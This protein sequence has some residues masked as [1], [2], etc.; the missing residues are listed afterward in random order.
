MSKAH[1]RTQ[2][3]VARCLSPFRETAVEPWGLVFSFVGVLGVGWGVLGR[4]AVGPHTVQSAGWELSALTHV[5]FP[6]PSPP[7]SEESAQPQELSK[8]IPFLT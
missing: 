1:H 3:P 4:G 8:R 7:V 2:N 6:T 5:S